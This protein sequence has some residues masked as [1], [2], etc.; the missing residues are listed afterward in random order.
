[1]AP[2]HLQRELQHLTH[3]LFRQDPALL[4][5]PVLEELLDDVIAEDVRRQLAHPGALK[6]RMGPKGKALLKDLLESLLLLLLR[7]HF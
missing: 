2:I 1:M 3:Q 4:H 6:A 5:I 7:G